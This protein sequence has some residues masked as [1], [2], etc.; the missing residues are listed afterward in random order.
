[1]VSRCGSQE[2]SGGSHSGTNTFLYFHYH[3][4]QFPNSFFDTDLTESINH[5]INQL[6]IHVRTIRFKGHPSG[7][8]TQIRRGA[9][10]HIFIRRQLQCGSFSSHA[11][12]SGKGG[13]APD[14]S[15]PVGADTVLGRQSRK[16]P[17]AWPAFVW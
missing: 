6:S 4:S 11:R 17:L 15:A 5:S 13:A 14:C 8:G 3:T 9:G 1:L 7:T 16:R 2:K 10:G 12:G